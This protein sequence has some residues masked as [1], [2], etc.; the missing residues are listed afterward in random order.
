M[1][2]RYT[3]SEAPNSEISVL[4]WPSETAL[5]ILLWHMLFY[6][7]SFLVSWGEAFLPFVHCH[8]PSERSTSGPS[9][10]DLLLGLQGLWG[11]QFLHVDSAS[12]VSKGTG[13][14]FYKAIAKQQPLAGSKLM[15]NSFHLSSTGLWKPERVLRGPE[16]LNCFNSGSL[17]GKAISHSTYIQDGRELR[18]WSPYAN[19]SLKA[20]HTLVSTY[21]NQG[22]TIPSLLAP[23]ILNNQIKMDS[24]YKGAAPSK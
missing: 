17:R 18:A 9:G 5:G 8:W 13:E 2:V 1:T 12:P 7:W 15:W 20:L 16:I 24:M 21:G 11:T 14:E 19:L 3:D 6:P 23:L 22:P 10:K 4:R